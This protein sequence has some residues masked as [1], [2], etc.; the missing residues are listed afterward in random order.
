MDAG[1]ATFRPPQS[2]EEA[3]GEARE[4]GKG[5]VD[6]FRPNAALAAA[7]LFHASAA[8]RGVASTRVIRATLPGA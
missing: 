4:G 6:G 7:A 1:I 5:D 3:N 8:V 2:R